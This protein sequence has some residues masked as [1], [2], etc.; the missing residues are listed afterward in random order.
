MCGD[1]KLKLRWGGVVR[2][3]TKEERKV[4]RVRTLTKHMYEKKKI[5]ME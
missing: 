4:M 5:K 1:V 2:R 3:D